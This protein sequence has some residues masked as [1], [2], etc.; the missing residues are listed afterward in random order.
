MTVNETLVD[1]EVRHA[2]YI[3]R[4][5]AGTIKKIIKLLEEAEKEIVAKLQSRSATLEGSFTSSRLQSLLKAVREINHDGS[6]AIGKELTAELKNLAR[7][8]A[9]FQESLFGKV[10]PV[11]FDLVT[12]SKELLDAV[13]NSRPLQGRFLKDLVADLEA[14]SIKRLTS[15]IQLGMIQGETT[16]QIV[17]RITGTSALKFTDG[18]S[19]ITRRQATNLVRTATNHVANAA[20]EKFYEAN[21][22][23][24]SSVQWVA[25]LDTRTCEICG[26]LDGETFP[27]DKGPRPP[28][29]PSCRCSTVPVVKSWKELGIDLQEAPEGT[30]ASMNGQVAAS[31]SYS[32]WLAKQSS[33]V[34]N[35]ALGPTKAAL[36]RDGGLAI[37]GFVDNKG[38]ILTIDQLKAKEADAFEKAGL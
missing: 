10:L 15:A 7:Y 3:Q 17:S 33:A 22:D 30:R 12:P 24:I 36:F 35:E 37:D 20:R 32:D 13:V 25:T 21:E 16:S 34:Q 31:M 38:N 28:A 11:N 26:A 4:L 5:A 8:E 18:V 2:V 23:L 1:L 9:E 27:I 29:H 14:G 19:A 6:V